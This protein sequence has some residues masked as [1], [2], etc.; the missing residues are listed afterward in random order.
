MPERRKISKFLSYVLR[1]NP[2]KIGI[3]LDPAGWTPVPELL[4]H[5]AENGMH[6]SM[7]RLRDV[8]YNS[9]KQ[10]FTLSKN[11]KYIRAN[12]GHSVDVDL[13]YEPQPPPDTLYHGTAEQSVESILQS[14]LE[15]RSRQ[16]VHLST[17]VPSAHQVGSRHG[18]PVILE[19]DAGRAHQ[20]GHRFYQSDAG[21]WL[22]DEVPAEYIELLDNP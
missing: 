7:S 15:P 1:H 12:Y 11:E 10:R 2:D 8:I 18:K 9:S 3:R 17:D 22:T 14:G 5:A 20:D 4:D 13:G 6:I 19:I 21:I 16:Y